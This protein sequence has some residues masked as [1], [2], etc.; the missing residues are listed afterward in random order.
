MGSSEIERRPHTEGFHGNMF[1]FFP[2]SYSF[3]QVLISQFQKHV[4]SLVI[5]AYTQQHNCDLCVKT[6]T[7]RNS[8][9]LAVTY[10]FKA[11]GKSRQL[12]LF[13]VQAGIEWFMYF[14]LTKE[15]IF[16]KEIIM[17]LSKTFLYHLSKTALELELNKVSYKFTKLCV[18]ILAKINIS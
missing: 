13:Q 1:P 17:Q 9:V 6:S 8:P 3:R 10:I 2:M 14:L 16:R 12:V 18:N 11:R 7:A 15:L 5:W 4:H